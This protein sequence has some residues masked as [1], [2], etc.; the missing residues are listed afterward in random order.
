MKNPDS[1]YRILAGDCISLMEKMP[2]GSVDMIFADPPY[3]LQLGGELHRPDHSLVDAV[4]DDWDRFGDF[5]EYD[6]FTRDWLS[7]AR[8]VLK[9]DGSLWVIGS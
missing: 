7:A 9:E 5:A 6:R 2:A 4:D 8:H 3:N 1:G